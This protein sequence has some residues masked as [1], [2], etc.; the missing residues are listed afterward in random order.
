MANT[1]FPQTNLLE[2]LPNK[3]L[4]TA[5]KLVNGTIIKTKHL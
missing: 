1:S 5:Q 4:P 2:K 3:I